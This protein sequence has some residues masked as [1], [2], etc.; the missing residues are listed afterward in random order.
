MTL[1][2][3]TT[4]CHAALLLLCGGLSVACKSKK[5]DPREETAIRIHTAPV[6]AVAFSPDGLILASASEDRSIR[7]FNL[8]DGSL[9][10]SAPREH[11]SSPL[12][13]SGE[14]ITALSFSPDSTRLAAGEYQYIRGPLANIFD[15]EAGELVDQYGVSPSMDAVSTSPVTSLE[16]HPT[17]NLLVTGTGR[18]NDFGGVSVVNLESGE[19]VDPPIIADRFGGVDDVAISPDG[20]LLA[21]V[22]RFDTLRIHGLPD[23]PDIAVLEESRHYPATVAFSPDGRFLATTGDEE[24]DALSAYRGVVYIWEVA[25]GEMVTF[26]ELS[27]LPFRTLAYSPDGDIIAAAGEDHLIYLVGAHSHELLDTMRGHVGPVNS[28]AF[29]PNGSTLASGS[30]DHYLRWWD[31]ADLED[32][33]IVETDSGLDTDSDTLEMETDSSDT[34]EQET[35]TDDTSMISTDSDTAGIIPDG[36]GPEDTGIDSDTIVDTASDSEG[37]NDAGDSTDA[38][39][40]GTDTTQGTD[41]DAPDSGVDDGGL[42]DTASDSDSTGGTDSSIDTATGTDGL[43]GDGGVDGGSDASI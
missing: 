42:T 17:E 7:M 20:A 36:G 29:S 24:I 33:P 6:T 32:E 27:K 1:F 37:L 18:D 13:G 11:S 38:P 15:V 31:V 40:D 14:G 41:V 5:K 28:V 25:S 12:W 19:T 3:R 9:S 39:T 35:E 2:T 10:T 23:E 4:L 16:W 22:G 21:T 43:V 26:I 34:G 30:D 8:E